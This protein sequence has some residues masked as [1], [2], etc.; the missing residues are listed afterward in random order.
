[1]LFLTPTLPTLLP[2]TNYYIGLTLTGEIFSWLLLHAYMTPE[3]FH[4]L[5]ETQ[6]AEIVGEGTHIGDRRDEEHIIFLYQNNDLY[7][8]VYLNKQHGVI[9]KLQALSR[10]ELLDIYT[11]R[12]GFSIK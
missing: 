11:F 7:I 9:K 3:Q 2:A 4:K 5:D 10:S 6:Q 1:M 8:E 12:T